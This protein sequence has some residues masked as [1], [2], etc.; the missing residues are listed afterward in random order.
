LFVRGGS[1]RSAGGDILRLLAFSGVT[2][3][4]SRI[5]FRGRNDV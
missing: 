2:L 5:A 1:L 3:F 4:I